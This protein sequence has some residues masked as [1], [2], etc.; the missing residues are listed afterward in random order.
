M[1]TFSDI[2]IDIEEFAANGRSPAYI[3]TKLTEIY[4]IPFTETQVAKIIEE[5]GY[6][7]RRGE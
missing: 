4:K 6:G 5:Y 3:A 1:G 2:L 7:C